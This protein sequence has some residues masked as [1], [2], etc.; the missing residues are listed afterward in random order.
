M[1]HIGFNDYMNNYHQH[2][3]FQL[4]ELLDSF[5]KLPIIPQTLHNSS[6]QM[7]A[8]RPQSNQ[9]KDLEKRRQK[10][11]FEFQTTSQQI[12]CGTNGTAYPSISRG[13]PH[14]ELSKEH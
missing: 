8:R 2:V 12:L 3:N 5:K 4:S 14:R 7:S 1:L 10:T 6:F 9:K 11:F 13:F